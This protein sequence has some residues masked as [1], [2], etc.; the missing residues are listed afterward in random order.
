MTAPLQLP[1]G[2]T[3][4]ETG[5]RYALHGERIAATVSAVSAHADTGLFGIGAA[6]SAK[7]VSMAMLREIASATKDTD[8]SEAVKRA[9]TAPARIRDAAAAAGTGFHAYAEAYC[10]ALVGH[11]DAL[12]LSPVLPELPT[13]PTQRR[14]AGAVRRFIEQHIRNPL[15]VEV[16]LLL[17]GDNPVA[18]TADLV[19]HLE[20]REGVFVVD[21]KGVS[22]L[23][24]GDKASH[25]VQLEAYAA[26][27]EASGNDIAGTI[28]VKIERSTGKIVASVFERSP[29]AM[30]I[31][32]ACLAIHRWRVPASTTNLEEQGENGE[33]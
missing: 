32:H 21:W 22:S 4:E 18:G 14:C 7:Q 1:D 5:H 28:L 8:L 10:R 25:V 26:M 20:G 29:E 2:L 33:E 31:F 16:R 19:T 23:A 27:L 11:D 3:F 13:E 24:Y 17:P 6:W 15:G 30:E 9:K 12:G